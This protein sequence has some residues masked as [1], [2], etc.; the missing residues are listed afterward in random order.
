MTSLLPLEVELVADR[1]PGCGELFGATLSRLE[2]EQL[3]SQDFLFDA[4]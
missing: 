2:F 1:L 4:D 3:L